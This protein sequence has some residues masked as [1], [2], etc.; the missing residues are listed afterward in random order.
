MRGQR[1]GGGERVLPIGRTV[2]T[3]SELAQEDLG[4]NDVRTDIRK[5]GS[6]RS[7]KRANGR[8]KGC[9]FRRWVPEQAERDQHAQVGSSERVK[10]GR[11]GRGAA[12]S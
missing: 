4:C 11:P 6:G 7:H 1:W 3:P 5:R 8:E 12:E 9:S 2:K 10:G